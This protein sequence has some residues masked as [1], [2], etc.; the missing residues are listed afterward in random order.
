MAVKID[1]D[2][3]YYLAVGV[4][5]W[6]RFQEGSVYMVDTETQPGRTGAYMMLTGMVVAGVHSGQKTGA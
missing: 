3:R 2:F 1:S 5:S 4:W 6:G